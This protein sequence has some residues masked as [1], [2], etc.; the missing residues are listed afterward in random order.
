MSVSSGTLSVGALFAT[1]ACGLMLVRRDS[2]PARSKLGLFASVVITIVAFSI[3]LTVGAVQNLE[4]FGGGTSGLVAML[5][6]GLG[7]FFL[8]FGPLGV[9]SVGI[10][11]F[12]AAALSLGAAWRLPIRSALLVLALLP[13]A[14]GGL[15]GISTLVVGIVP[16]VLV[17]RPSLL[18]DIAD[19]VGLPHAFRCRGARPSP[20]EGPGSDALR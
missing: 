5:D 19:V 20:F 1:L 10:I 6:H 4:Y 14:L 9:A 7:R 2:G 13:V 3:S 15:F 12:C 11:A 8:R 16:L 18:S 17:L